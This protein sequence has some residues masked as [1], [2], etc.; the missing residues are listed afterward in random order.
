MNATYRHHMP[1][2]LTHNGAADSNGSRQA[3]EILCNMVEN[4]FYAP[5]EAASFLPI[6]IEVNKDLRT[7][8]SIEE[9][10]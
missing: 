8:G 4:S 6:R 2:P 5:N 9:E 3:R 10:C 7:S 1:L